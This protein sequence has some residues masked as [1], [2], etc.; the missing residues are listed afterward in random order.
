[1]SQTRKLTLGVAGTALLVA[2]IL[3]ASLG[4]VAAGQKQSLGTGAQ[5]AGG[6]LRGDVTPAHWV[7]CLPSASWRVI[8]TWDGVAQVWNHHFNTTKGVPSYVNDDDVGGITSIKRLSGVSI[9]MDQP[10][11]NPFFPDSSSEQCPT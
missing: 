4:I 8:Y 3:G 1:M 5:L 6:P 11:T 7:S 2:G 9:V 10:V